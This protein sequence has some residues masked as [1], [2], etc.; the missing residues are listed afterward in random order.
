VWRP[1]DAGPLA[2]AVADP[3]AGDGP[4]RR[5]LVVAPQP[6]YEDRGTPIAELQV[7]RALSQLSYQVDVLTYP[8]GRTPAI[9]RVQYYR[10]PNPLG[11]RWVPI[12]LSWRKLWL[13]LFLLPAIRKRLRESQYLCIHAVE[14]AAFLAVMV[15]R[16]YGV[17]VVYDMQSSMAEQLASMRWLGSRPARAV[18]FACE[19]WLL[20]HATYTLSSAG[21]AEKV[22]ARVPDARIRDWRYPGST[23]DVNAEDV[24][25]LRAEL[26][27][28]DDRAVVLYT[29]TFEDYQ[30]LPTLI[31]AIP[32][33]LSRVPHAV[34][35]FVGASGPEGDGVARR[36]DARVP[37]DSYR[38]VARQPR[39]R[40][41]TF[42]ALARVVV[43]PRVYGSNLPIK[44]LEYLAAG[45]AIVATSIPAHLAILNEDLAVLAEPTSPSLGAAIGGLLLDPGRISA[46]QTAARAYA[47]ENVDWLSFVRLIGSVY[48]QVIPGVRRQ[49]TQPDRQRVGGQTRRVSGTAGSPLRILMVAPEPFFRPRGTPFSVLHRIRALLR[50]GHTVDL[51]T[52]PFGDSPCL[53]GLSIHRSARP[54]VVRDVA[55]GPSV[56]KVLLDVPLF[57]KAY[58]LARTS[59]FDLVH[60]HE[61]AGVL[62]T[63][64][65]RNL[66]IPH[67]YD[68]HSS[69]PQQFA[70]FDRFNWAPVV[71]A[72]R[73]LE[74]YTLAGADA[75]IAICPDLRDH[76]IASRYPGPLALIENT[77]DFE[78]PATTAAEIASVRKRLD[79]DGARVVLYT[80]TIE[81][82]QGLD[83]LVSAAAAVVHRVP[84]VRFVVVGGTSAQHGAIRRHAVTCGVESS[85]VLVPAVPPTEIF[86]Y[87]Q[88][89]DVLVST[90]SKGTNTP[91]K[92]YQY[93]RAGKPI[94][95][96]ALRSH[97]QVLTQDTAE[98][99]PPSPEGVASGL[100]RVLTDEAYGRSLAEGATR[101]AR[102]EYSEEVHM[103]R[104]RS[105]LERL[106]ATHSRP[107]AA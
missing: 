5:I 10:V 90:R 18:L 64:I 56:A 65:A 20:R 98:L 91:L 57:L 17:P 89:A 77:L 45:S 66:G 84:A 7:F 100:L 6:F 92:I 1:S 51:V 26:D 16:R 41:P 78:M 61:E 14:E 50:L 72:F 74:R 99:V 36:L 59:R 69:L 83:L 34:F 19:R 21:L 27:I 3:P 81:P 53:P 79:L 101:L 55:I 29:G 31:D 94:V 13:D 54:P 37:A 63:R 102:E 104:L 67:L 76:V 68:M 70:N 107:P 9:Q 58:R 46:L 88:V 80:G 87:H 30:G 42:L 62:G 25:R 38:V 44:V 103:A 93:L 82:Y 60:T 35:V 11:I 97:T 86:L 28:A 43:S 2:R 75:V 95:A 47:R 4:P 23:P 49:W 96:T 73:R 15:A 106:P 40:I 22:R 48:N 33:V 52:Y 105:L 32:G 71:S 8:V 24:A 85:F 12:G 39:E